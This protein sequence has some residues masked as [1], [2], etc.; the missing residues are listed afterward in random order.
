M[1]IAPPPGTEIKPDNFPTNYTTKIYEEKDKKL[2]DVP[3]TGGSKKKR[4]SSKKNKRT[5]R[6]T[7]S[8]KNKRKS[9]NLI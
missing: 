2:V 7:L 9:F 6:S 5:R 1:D 8:K 4:K 3:L